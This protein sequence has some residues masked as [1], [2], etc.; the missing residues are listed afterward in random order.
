MCLMVLGPGNHCSPNIVYLIPGISHSHR[1]QPL[2]DSTRHNP[3]TD[4]PE[5]GA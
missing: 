1:N 2:R 5:P 4:P 3:P